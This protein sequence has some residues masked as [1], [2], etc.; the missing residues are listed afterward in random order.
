MNRIKRVKTDRFV[1][2]ANEILWNKNL[3]AKAKGFYAIIMGLPETW[4]FTMSGLAKIVKESKDAIASGID[5]LEA[6]G[7]VVKERVKDKK[8][9]FSGI[10]YTFFETARIAENPFTGNPLSENTAQVNTISIENNK[11]SYEDLSYLNTHITHALEKDAIGTAE[12]RPQ[13]NLVTKDWLDQ[14]A[15]PERNLFAAF[16]E[17]FDQRIALGRINQTHIIAIRS[18]VRP[19]DEQAWQETIEDYQLAFD[20]V[21]GRYLPD[22]IN[23]VLGVFRNKKQRIERELS[24][25][26]TNQQ[27]YANSKQRRTDADVIRESAE[28]YAKWRRNVEQPDPGNALSPL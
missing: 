9:R 16:P 3:S 12:E 13:P 21:I 24:Q 14:W 23:N 1:V 18:A 5:E 27:P 11:S 10:N 7:Y 2:M 25:N 4:D 28:F 15:W 22:K 6:A 20:P 17:Y 26:G 8:G 19:G